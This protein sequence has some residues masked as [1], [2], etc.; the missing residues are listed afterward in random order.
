MRAILI[1]PGEELRKEFEQAIVPHWVLHISRILDDYPTPEDL[2]RV[3]RAW[4]PEIVF[5]NIEN[6]HMAELIGRQLEAEF[7]AIQRVALH[8]SQDVTV[9]RQVL[10]LHMTQLLS[11][12]FESVEVGQVLDQLERD[13]EVRPVVIDSTD[14]FFCV[15][16]RESRRRGLDYRRQY[17][18]GLQSD[19]KY[20]RLAGRF[21]YGFGRD[22]VHVQ[23][24]A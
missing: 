16:A 19:G 12:P 21:R 7:P 22:R 9:L 11:S 20:Q 1:C 17:H 24:L 15:Y 6:M 4:A 13:L 5:L 2:R 23:H 8:P 14:R 18:L 10:Q 3:V